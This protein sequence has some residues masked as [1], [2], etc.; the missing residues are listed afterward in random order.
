MKRE[1]KRELGKLSF[2][3]AKILLAVGVFAPFFKEEFLHYKSLSI[4]TLIVILL[5][6]IGAYFIN[7]GAKNNE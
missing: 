6:I 5:I 3:V 2:D 4:S 1:T 7:R